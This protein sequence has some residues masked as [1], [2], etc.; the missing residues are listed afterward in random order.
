MKLRHTLLAASLLIAAASHAQQ[1]PPPQ[2]TD[3]VA[4]QIMQGF[5]PPPDKTVRL[6]N[7]LQYPNARWAFHHMRELGPTAAI[8]RGAGPASALTKA[9]HTLGDDVR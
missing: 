4:L 7:V 5:P 8:W 2:A 1:L 3:P 6:A 9:A